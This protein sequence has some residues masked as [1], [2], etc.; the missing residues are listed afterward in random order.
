MVT[1]LAETLYQRQHP[2]LVPRDCMSYC[3]RHCDTS[4]SKK[5]K[6]IV[7]EAQAQGERLS[8]C[9]QLRPSSLVDSAAL[10]PSIPAAR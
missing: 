6:H 2:R 1:S 9:A 5:A 7:W 4:W 8:Q 3:A 10:N